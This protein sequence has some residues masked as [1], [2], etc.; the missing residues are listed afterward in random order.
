MAT[1]RLYH[2]DAFVRELTA[3]VVAHGVRDGRPT[4]V[5]D[6]TVFYP[7]AGGQLADQGVLAGAR[8]VDVQVDDDG[9]IHHLCEPGAEVPPVGAEVAG[10]I[11][12]ARRRQHMAQHTGQHM[13]S[14]ALL[15]EAGAATASS[16]LGE[17]ACTIDVTRDR[18]PDAELARAEALANA[19]VDDD[20]AIRVWFPDV[21]ELAALPLRREPKVEADI[22]IVAIGD[23]DLSPCGGT[24]CAR[25]AQ[26]GPI[27]VLAAERHK[28]MTRVTFAAGARAR[29]ELAARDEVLRGLGTAFTC[30]PGEVPA[31]VD[32][33]RRD[34]ADVRAQL[35]ATTTRLAALAAAALLAAP[36][37]APV[38]AVVDGDVELLRAVAARVTGAGR[39]AVLAGPGGDGTAVVLA[40]AAGSALDCGALMRALAGHAGGRGGGRPDRAEGRLPAGVDWPALVAAARAG[41]PG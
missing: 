37:A 41:D 39:D 10:A 4:V 28:G 16:R 5:L 8:V 31:A 6:R 7:E 32:K 14:Q 20:L 35:A 29:D 17:R 33:L 23:F 3:R 12:W 24:H 27:R 22:R 36:G 26:V 11:D 30:A 13:L 38:V 21:R 40:R 15:A 1:E 9:T 25:T 19:V 18:I 34:L 2:A